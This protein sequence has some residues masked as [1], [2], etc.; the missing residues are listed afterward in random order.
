MKKIS[1]FLITTLLLSTVVQ[2]GWKWDKDK[3][4]DAKNPSYT[5]ETV[6]APSYCF[7]AGWDLSLYGSGYWPENVPNNGVGGGVALGY[8]FNENL[9]FDLSYTA[10]GSGVSQQIGMAN[11]VYRFPIE[12]KWCSSFAPYIHGG[13]GVLSQGASEFSWDIGG[14]VDVRFESWGCVGVFADY[15]YGFT[16]DNLQDFSMVRLGMKFPF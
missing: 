1:A 9:G 3:Y 12:S 14:G 10:H 6:T 13:P 11:L 4:H 2:A 16:D 7:D 5:N 15:T 8:F